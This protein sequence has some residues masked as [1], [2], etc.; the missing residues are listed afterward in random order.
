M[1]RADPV[2]SATLFAKARHICFRH[3]AQLNNVNRATATDGDM[4]SD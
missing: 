4:P 2:T 3:N 1:S